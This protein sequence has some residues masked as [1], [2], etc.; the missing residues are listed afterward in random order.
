MVKRSVYQGPHLTIFITLVVGRSIAIGAAL[1]FCCSNTIY[2]S[3][4]EKTIF[5]SLPQR[6]LPPFL[7]IGSD[8]IWDRKIVCTTLELYSYSHYSLHLYEVS[9]F[10][11][12]VPPKNKL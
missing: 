1:S 8:H 7:C 5:R 3:I 4:Q 10:G 9:L 2:A 6:V 12:S 11:Y